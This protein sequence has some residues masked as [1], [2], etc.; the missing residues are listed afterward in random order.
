MKIRFIVKDNENQPVE[1]AKVDIK[2]G[3]V[4][5]ILLTMNPLKRFNNVEGDLTVKYD[6]AKGNLTG[7]GGAV[8]SFEVEFTP[9]D[10]VQTPNP[11]IT[12]TLTVEMDQINIDFL[13]I[14]YTEA[15]MIETEKITV[16]PAET[17]IMLTHVSVINP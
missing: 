12:D 11:G 9:T 6:A 5:T 14:T 13:K 15:Y 4:D 2:Y 8:E 10:L 16:A 3:L 7:A 17:T 1:S